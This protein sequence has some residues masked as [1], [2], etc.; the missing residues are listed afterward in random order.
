[1]PILTN[2]V[3]MADGSTSHLMDLVVAPCEDRNVDFFPGRLDAESHLHKISCRCR[4][5]GLFSKYAR[6]RYFIFI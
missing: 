3:H 1:M 4:V 6:N 5:I 2:R